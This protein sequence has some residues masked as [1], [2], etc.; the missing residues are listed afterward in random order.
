MAK[1]IV[2]SLKLTALAALF[3]LMAGMPVFAEETMAE[4][5]EEEAVETVE[6]AIESLG[7]K[8]KTLNQERM[9]LRRDYAR[10][11]TR[12]SRELGS[13]FVGI[14]TWGRAD[15]KELD[16]ER[17]ALLEERERFANAYKES[18]RVLSERIRELIAEY[19][20]KSK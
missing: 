11:K 2:I 3:L 13:F 10:E 14:F 18:D 17:A 16:H 19:L 20:G 9:K 7:T 15:R 6:T 1:N 4:E 8:I 12:I 5:Q